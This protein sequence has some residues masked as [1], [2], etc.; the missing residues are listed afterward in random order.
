MNC[1]V[2]YTK[3]SSM[4]ITKPNVNFAKEYLKKINYVTNVIILSFAHNLIT[5]FRIFYSI[6]KY[7]IYISSSTIIYK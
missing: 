2:L 3:L 7:V 5:F 1:L 6:Q 4:H